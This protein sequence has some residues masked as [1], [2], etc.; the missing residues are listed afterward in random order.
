MKI[1]NPL[2]IN[3][4]GLLTTSLMRRWMDTL[5]LRWVL[6]DRANDTAVDVPGRRRIYLFWHEYVLMPLDRRGHTNVTML[7]SRHRDG[8]VLARI[9]KH[10]GFGVVRGSTNDG[11][12]TSLRELI[13]VSRRGHLTITPDG[14]R[15]PRRELA[16]GPIYLASKLG[17]PIVPMGYGYDR[18]WRANS[19]DRFALPRPFSRGRAVWGPEMCIPK[20]LDRDGLEHY[21]VE[22][23]RMINRLTLEAEAW[24]EAGTRKEGELPWHREPLR[25]GNYVAMR[26]EC[27]MEA[28]LNRRAA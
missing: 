4:A 25:R 2:V 28:E 1:T 21:R 6:Y 27:A 11:A 19:W 26:E 10:Q 15:G 17:L 13:Q 14:P 24:A 3:T 23:E 7:L 20:K 5:D 18:P 16:V 22:V 12:S 8:D 9:A